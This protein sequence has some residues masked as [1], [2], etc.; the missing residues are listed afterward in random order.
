MN[1]SGYAITLSRPVSLVFWFS[2]HFLAAAAIIVITAHLSMSRYG[3]AAID[4]V[5][6]GMAAT[7]VTS[8]IVLTFYITS[9]APLGF[10]RLMPIVLSPFSIFFL[11]LLL[12]HSQQSRLILL[13]GFAAA[14]TLSIFP[15]SL[16]NSLQWPALFILGL[17]ILVPAI[18][19]SRARPSEAIVE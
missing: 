14:L 9:E 5:G 2:W 6:V 8:A 19:L 13:T 10:A 18:G 15:L 3:A 11:F 4:T 1:L 16:K 7:Y 12:T 17:I